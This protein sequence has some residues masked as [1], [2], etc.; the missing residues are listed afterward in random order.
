MNISES[1]IKAHGALLTTAVGEEAAWV[2]LRHMKLREVDTGEALL[3]CGEQTE[4]LF[5]LCTGELQAFLPLPADERLV[6]GAVTPGQWLGEVNVIDQGL[7]S[8]TVLATK[9]SQLFSL[10]HDALAEVEA[11]R[12][13]VAARLLHKLTQDLAGRLRRSTTGVVERVAGDEYRLASVPEKRTW[14]GRLL[15]GL[16]GARA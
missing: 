4:E 7:A 6:F 13:D 11:A 16:L 12:P 9:P 14:L 5:V 8:A 1:L 3:R 15:G 10:S 2:L